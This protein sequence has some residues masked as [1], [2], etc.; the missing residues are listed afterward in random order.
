MVDM[1]IWFLALLL[2]IGSVKALKYFI[3]QVKRDD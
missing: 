3:E 1:L 2:I